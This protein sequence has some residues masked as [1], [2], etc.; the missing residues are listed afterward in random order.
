MA[1][2]RKRR[3]NPCGRRRRRNPGTNNWLII[4]G[5]AA[6]AYWWIT[7]NPAVPTVPTPV[8]P[9]HTGPQTQA[10]YDAWKVAMEK[11][12]QTGGVVPIQGFGDIHDSPYYRVR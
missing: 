1:R 3:R 4:G 2:R 6:A 8:L 7:R 5:L 11:A 10:E 9:L 12:A